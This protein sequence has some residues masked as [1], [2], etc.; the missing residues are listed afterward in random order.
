MVGYYDFQVRKRPDRAEADRYTSLMDI[1]ADACYSALTSRG[2]RSGG[3]FLVGVT[4]TRIYCQPICRMTNLRDH[5][6]HR[7][8]NGALLAEARD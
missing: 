7:R 3:V 6:K 5:E 1:D 8:W 2:T 4:I